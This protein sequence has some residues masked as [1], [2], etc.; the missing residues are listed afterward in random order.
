MYFFAARDLN[1]LFFFVTI[2]AA[3]SAANLA[4]VELFNLPLGLPR[5]AGTPVGAWD[6]FEARG[7]LGFLGTFVVDGAAAAS[8]GVVLV[9]GTVGIVGAVGVVEIVEIIGI[10]GIAGM[11]G[12]VGTLETLV[13]VVDVEMA[14]SM[15]VLLFTSIVFFDLLDRTAGAFTTF[16]L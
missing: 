16:G 8:T 6:V 4:T 10:F 5:L 15:G 12:M 14:G 13:V 7:A 2:P 9:V 1:F 11:E 3:A